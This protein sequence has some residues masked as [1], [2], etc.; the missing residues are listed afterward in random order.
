MGLWITL[1]LLPSESCPVIWSPAPVIAVPMA[2]LPGAVPEQRMERACQRSFL[3]S[4]FPTS[5]PKAPPTGPNC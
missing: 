2:R 4:Y 1:R 5:V 3:I